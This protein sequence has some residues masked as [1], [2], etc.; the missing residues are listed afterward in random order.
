MSNIQDSNDSQSIIDHSQLSSS[1]NQ[2][3]VDQFVRSPGPDEP[4]RHQNGSKFRYCNQSNCSYKSNILSNFRKHLRNSHQIETSTKRSD[5]QLIG[6]DQLNDV[7]ITTGGRTKEDLQTSIFKGFLNKQIIRKA[8]VQLITL[9]RLALSIVEWPAFHAFIGAFNPM[10]MNFVPTSHNTIRADIIN[11]WTDEKV[12]LRNH[13][14]TARSKINISLDIWTSP[15]TLLFLGVV[16]HFVRQDEAVVSKALLGLRTVGSHSGEEQ[17]YVLQQVLEEYEITD[18]L[19]VIIG[20]NATTN[21]TLCRTIGAWFQENN[22]PEW[23]PQLQRIRCLGHIINLI[24][25]AFLFPGSQK[26]PSEEDLNLYD[27]KDQE[28]TEPEPSEEQSRGDKFRSMGAIGKLHNIVVHI[29]CSGPRTNEFV[30]SSKRRI[31]LDN[32]TRWNSWYSMLTVACE[33][34]KELDFYTKNHQ[35]DLRKDILSAQDWEWLRTIHS[36]LKVFCDVTLENEGDK[37]DI[38]YVLPSLY[39]LKWHIE[40]VKRKYNKPKVRTTLKF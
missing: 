13:L 15:N 9:H 34:E 7:Y 16:A 40:T 39:V 37:K 4:E 36:F 1:S 27:R 14:R 29:R 6:L 31:P 11:L 32:R 38:S 25:Q 26:S 23:D 3:D 8:L 30:K 24:V 12:I 17:F 19:G 35:K 33:L 21:D 10:A 2:L 22:R 5:I 18:N 28:G 20:D